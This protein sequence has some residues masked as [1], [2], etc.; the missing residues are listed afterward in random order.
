[1]KKQ[2][3]FLP[4]FL[5]GTLGSPAQTTEWSNPST[6]SCKNLSGKEVSIHA[7][8]EIK[9]L[10]SKGEKPEDGNT[11]ILFR[12]DNV[13]ERH[14]G[15]KMY[16]QMLL[17][18]D[19]EALGTGNP[20]NPSF[21]FPAMGTDEEAYALAEYKI[22]ANSSPDMEHPT[23][24]AG[25]CDS[26][27]VPAGIY[28]IAI[29]VPDT[30]ANHRYWC[31]QGFF[32]D[33]V[34]EEGAVYEFHVADMDG[35]DQCFVTAD[36][37][38]D[39]ALLRLS[40]PISGADL[41]S[42]EHLVVE[43]CNNGDYLVPASSASLR[44]SVDGK[45]AFEE[46]LPIEIPIGDTLEYTLSTP[47]D[48]STI[49]EHRI[50][51]ELIYDQDGL[52]SNNTLETT[53][54]KL[55]A[56]ETLPYVQDFSSPDDAWT[57]YDFLDDLSVWTHNAQ[58]GYT[59]PGCMYDLMPANGGS[60][61]WLISPPIQLEAGEAYMTFYYRSGHA[62][63]PASLE[64]W[65]GPSLDRSEMQLQTAQTAWTTEWVLLPVN[66]QVPESGTY[67]FAIR[68]T[69]GQDMTD[70]SIDDVTI[71]QGSFTGIP[72]IS[73]DRIILPV[74]GCGLENTAISAV[75]SNHGSE[76]IGSFELEYSINGGEALSHSFNDLPIG[77][78]RTFT[79]PQAA[80][81]SEPGRYDIVLKARC[82]GPDTEENLDDNTDSAF[83]TH[84][85]PATLPYTSNM[86]AGEWVPTVPGTWQIEDG[87]VSMQSGE[88]FLISRCI[89]LEA[90]QHR[91]SYTTNTPLWLSPSSWQIA[92]GLSGS[93][94]ES[95]D[96]ICSVEE[97]FALRPGV[98]SREFLFEVEEAG[99]YTFSFDVSSVDFS[100]LEVRIEAVLE[101]DIRLESIV[102]D[103]ARMIPAGQTGG[104][105]DWELRIA[106][107]GLA[108]ENAVKAEI[109]KESDTLKSI[110]SLSLDPQS[111][112]L[113]HLDFLLPIL[114][115]GKHVFEA[116]VSVPYDDLVPEDN[117][118]AVEVIASDSTFAFDNEEE[119]LLGQDDGLASPS[120]N[121]IGIW[122]EL[123]AQDTLTSVSIG[124]G[125][126]RDIPFGL[127]VHK[128]GKS[129]EGEDSLCMLM[130]EKVLQRGTGGEYTCFPIN[131]VVME[132]GR[133]FIEVQQLGSD[134]I[135]LGH[136]NNPAGIC[137]MALNTNLLSEMEDLGYVAIRANFGHPRMIGK[138]AAVRSLALQKTEGLFTANEAV[139]AEVAN[140]GCE[141]LVDQTVLCLVDNKEYR[142]TIPL[143][144]ANTTS[145]VEFQV[146]L[147]QAGTRQIQVSIPLEGDADESDNQ[148][149][150]SVESWP[151]ADPY[152]LDFEYC[153]DFSISDF[154]PAWTTV[155]GDNASVYSLAVLETITYPNMSGRFAYMAF[156][157]SQTNPIIWLEDDPS[158]NA[159]FAPYA[160]NR[161]GVSFQSAAEQND[162]WLIS[163]KLRVGKGSEFVFHVSY[164]MEG[165]GVPEFQAYV[166][167]TGNNPE[168]FEPLGDKMTAPAG[169]WEEIRLSLD[170][171]AGQEIH[172]A[173]RCVSTLALMFMVDDLE[174]TKASSNEQEDLALNLHLYPNPARDFIQISTSASGIH[175]EQVEIFS[176][177]G[178]RLFAS[179][180]NL[181]QE[182]FRYDTSG[183]DSGI[184]FARVRTNLG[185]ATLKFIVL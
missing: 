35:Y 75:L 25:D 100:L 90:G 69:T 39:L 152:K 133:Y 80:D 46:D 150:A 8:L 111:D 102:T 67:H 110:D 42:Q 115:A 61:D 166:S 158:F 89:H 76:P 58:E 32:D 144:K 77:A 135:L 66:V 74:A 125:K 124:F 47:V 109:R 15:Y 118:L 175:M 157:P 105:T 176:I 9:K 26:L 65:F 17:D 21:G 95:H 122:Y 48:L 123:L 68:N 121:S 82:T 5:L 174:V 34:L 134:P 173:I 138:D 168:D 183:L 57:I 162:D 137:Y 149:S 171:Y 70:L 14:F 72:D 147:S 7:S 106:N 172:V 13:W 59:A 19:A 60:D 139:R 11:K 170:E 155:D 119:V 62:R 169:I 64:V 178:T 140:F 153:E 78:T 84:F 12:A 161:Y 167:T 33:F 97:E 129:R 28:D 99:D 24:L 6:L 151:P 181:H 104:R 182:Y 53:V 87:S 38:D 130:F 120:A 132:P 63:Y 143:L 37:P 91:F 4:V 142:L 10:Q 127:A 112:T 131:P 160:G 88:G 185:T 45:E 141:D 27:E 73:V 177:Q 113:F 159:G 49:G 52:L 30:S 29:I 55:Q 116:S 117:S 56:V 96:S 184:Y 40:S 180:G 92:Y 23:G 51:L 16:Y 165:L 98:V 83:T 146:D 43:I 126:G 154:Q 114:E 20:W 85:E 103:L 145:T 79:F 81:F 22:P 94:P 93:A 50:H 128:M 31:N 44:C 86:D 1:M 179:D 163:P 54:E 41:G 156:N 101:H 18:A 136:D 108:Y 2:L 71:D 148:K 3:L 36:V 107:R 164:P